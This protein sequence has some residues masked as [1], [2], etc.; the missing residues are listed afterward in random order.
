MHHAFLG[1]F[2]DIEITEFDHTVLGQENV[3]TLDISVNDGE[4]ME[5]F[6]ASHD[7]DEVVPDLFLS[8]LGSLLFVFLDSLEQIAVVGLLH[9]DAKAICGIFE[10]GLLVCD[11]IRVVNRSQNSN[12]VDSILFL[13]L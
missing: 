13:L 3:G 9:D 11:D 4:I 6:Q 10:E 12:L 1:N 7:L 2:G 8:K 5:S